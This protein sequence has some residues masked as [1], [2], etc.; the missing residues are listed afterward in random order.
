MEKTDCFEIGKIIKTFGYKGELIVRINKDFIKV[1][2]K[3][4]SVFIETDEELV[5]FFITEIE[6]EDQDYFRISFDDIDNVDIARNFTS[7]I[8]WLP[9]NALPQDFLKKNPLRDIR[10]YLVTDVEFGYVGKASEVINYPQHSVLQIL[11]GDKEIL[12]PV[13][14][15]FILGIDRKK[16]EILI[17]APAGLIESYLE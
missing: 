12:V 5:P 2:K 4:G 17:N 10:D 15:K 8:L 3:E 9:F 1:I 14:D 16:K 13:I 11:N 7:C 6:Q